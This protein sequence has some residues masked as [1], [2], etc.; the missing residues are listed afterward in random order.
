M[1]SWSPT[2]NAGAIEPDAML[3]AFH[4]DGSACAMFPVLAK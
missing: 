2:S 1:N 3:K 4:R